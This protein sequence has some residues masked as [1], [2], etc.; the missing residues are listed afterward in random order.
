MGHGIKG[1]GWGSFLT[2]TLLIKHRCPFLQPTSELGGRNAVG[3][4]P[5]VLAIEGYFFDAAVPGL[6]AG[7]IVAENELACGVF[8]VL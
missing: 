8:S 5:V 1:E 3:S 4:V 7:G 2:P 6:G